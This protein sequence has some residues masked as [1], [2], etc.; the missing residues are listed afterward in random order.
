MTATKEVVPCN[1]CGSDAATRV[2][3]SQDYRLRVDDERYGVVKCDRC[4]L[5][6]LCPRPTETAI[7]RYYPA[8]Y[9]RGRDEAG[10]GA[11]MTVQAEYLSDLG[12]G[13]LL[14]VGAARGDF[15]VR[16]IESGWDA[17]GYEPYAS[18][19]A[20]PAVP[21]VRTW[22]DPAL[23]PESFD[24]I[25]AW[26]VFEHM[27]DPKTAFEN[28][29]RLL[30]PGGKLIIHVPNFRSAFSRWSFQED[31]PRHLYFFSARTL[32]EYAD[33]AR[34]RLMRVH[35]DNRIMDGSGFG[36]LRVQAFRAFGGSVTEFFEWSR[37]G[38]W[39]ARLRA[40]PLLFLLFVPLAG[41]ERVV[42]GEPIRRL[43]GTNGYIVAEFERASR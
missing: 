22:D 29:A 9:Y 36:F 43:L 5:A 13:R 11:R 34:L 38:S 32:A 4:G 42:N 8:D 10:A 19:T 25:T 17:I 23:E 24:A 7:A 18:E 41:I 26:S 37:L 3:E 39:R 27:H 16:M 6:Y 20:A 31:V 1:L 40:R 2:Y 28:C 21:M 33:R 14:D 35:Q 30:R 15:V 12:P